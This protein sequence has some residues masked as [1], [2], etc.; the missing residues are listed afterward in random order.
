VPND[1]AMAARSGASLVEVRAREGL[2]TA[3]AGPRARGR[4]PK[5]SVHQEVHLAELHRSGDKRATELAELF[6]VGRSTVYRA[7]GR[8]ARAGYADRGAR[9][10]C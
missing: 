4:R 8:A 7:L 2:G 10:V 3:R 6:G 5:L 1:L 9:L